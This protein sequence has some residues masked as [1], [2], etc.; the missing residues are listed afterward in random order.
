M[1][2]RGGGKIPSKLENKIKKILE[3]LKN[4]EKSSL[5]LVSLSLDLGGAGY[6]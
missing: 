2:P 4:L 5:M 3:V 6:L 1:K